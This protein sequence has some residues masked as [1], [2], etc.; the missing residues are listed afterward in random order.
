M[1]RKKVLGFWDLALFS[2]CAIF[3][4]EAIAASAAIG[5]S[6][7]SWW[8]ICLVGFFLPFSLIAAELG[9]TYTEQ[10]GIYIWI[11]KAFGDKW[12]ARAIWYYWI[13]L[14]LWLPAMY[15]AIVQI[16][17]HLF[18]PNLTL[19]PQIFIG[20]VLIWISVLVNLCPL[21]FSKW[22]PNVGSLTRFLVIAGMIVAAIL[23]F[24]KNGRLANPITW[25]NV[26]PNLN[27][28]VIFI[29]MIIYNLLGCELI[30]G[31]AGEMKDPKRDVPKAVIFSAFIIAFF[32]MITTA[33]VWVVVP[34]ADINVA[35][36]I[37]QMFALAF[38]GHAAVSA[39]TIV[40]GLLISFTLF[41]EIVTWNLGENRTVAEAARN[42]ELPRVLGKMTAKSQAPLG[43]SV[44]SG[45]ISTVIIIV[46]GFI[47]KN[48]SELF[49]HVV[50]FSL[51]VE[52]F[53]YLMLFPAFIALRRKDKDVE[54]PYRVPGPEGFAIFLAVMVEMFILMAMVVLFLQPGK[55]FV[56]AAL[57]LIIGVVVTLGLGEVFIVRSR[58]RKFGS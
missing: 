48:S 20:I 18:F 30:S 32:Y 15:I 27:A 56:R 55:D 57:P 46:Y 1:E 54:R 11:K 31:A 43:A 35:S 14:P 58:S 2:F 10:G 50:S 13:A 16:L 5:P 8:L 53:T 37:F 4:V 9:S 19:W 38:E 24:L 42:G 34:I 49:W 44:A 40:T 28:A 6:A 41:A 23:Y 29:P 17:S 21:R 22:V 36:G 25:T 3:G 7:L 52:L 51:V 26:M 47:A 39:I 12:A 45:V 33:T